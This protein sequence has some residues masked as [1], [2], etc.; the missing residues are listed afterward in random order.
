[1]NE[2]KEKAF[3][4][5]KQKKS[6]N[7]IHRILGI[8]KSSLSNWFKTD[9][10][11]VSVKEILIKKTQANSVNR[12]RLMSLANKEKW[13]NIHYSYRKQ[14]EN[15]FLNLINEQFFVPGLLIY[16]GE[17]DKKLENGIVRIANVDHRMI[18]VFISFLL[19]SC[20]IQL[21]KLRLWLLL[22]PDL[23]EK[24]CK[25]YWSKMLGIPQN[26]F[27]KSQYIQGREKKKKIS[28]GVCSVQIYSREL[29]EKIIKW[30]DLYSEKLN[31]R[32]SYSGI[33]R[34]CQG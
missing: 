26:Q 5:R 15:D 23:D 22:Y 16:W 34:P 20:N 21:S 17:G 11:S 2:L 4:L 8:S 32:A 6:Y 27:I 12:L 1:M 24:E 29:K 18:Q 13:K 7:E 25:D 3:D 28:Y 14:A 19:S 10:Y 33:I 30:I 9:G 31:M